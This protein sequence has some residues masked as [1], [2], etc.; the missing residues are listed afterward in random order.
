M[1]DLAGL[2]PTTSAL[3]ARCSPCAE[4]QAQVPPPFG[5][6]MQL[7]DGTGVKVSQAAV[8]TLRVA[9][10]RDLLHLP[11]G[12]RKGPHGPQQIESNG[13]SPGLRNRL[14]APHHGGRAQ[15]ASVPPLRAGEKSWEMDMRVGSLADPSCVSGLLCRCKGA[16]HLVGARW[17]K[18]GTIPP[19]PRGSRS[20][21]RPVP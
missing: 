8:L 3:R 12:N 18:R 21:G 5:G 20:P 15:P 19:V 2:E 16:E 9:T 13:S 11:Q 1:V 14:S 4:L 6:G 17:W 7:S 10:D